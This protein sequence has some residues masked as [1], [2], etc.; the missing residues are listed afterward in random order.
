MVR[1]SL[2]ALAILSCVWLSFFS[3]P[4]CNTVVVV[5]GV[6]DVGL[7]AAA[8]SGVGA[9]AE[10]TLDGVAEADAFALAAADGVPATTLLLALAAG[11]GV[12]PG[13]GS[14][15]MMMKRALDTSLL[16]LASL[17]R[18]GMIPRN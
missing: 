18:G 1:A 11:A 3:E 9:A 10:G 14:S 4:A 13:A 7:A 17:L 6:D 16:R 15:S 5:S 8:D 2:S 12:A